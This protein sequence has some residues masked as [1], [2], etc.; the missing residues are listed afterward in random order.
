MFEVSAHPIRALERTESAFTILDNIIRTLALTYIDA[1]IEDSAA[2]SSDLLSSMAFNPRTV[3]NH[4]EMNSQRHHHHLSLSNQVHNGQY[5][6]APTSAHRTQSHVYPLP[7]YS[8]QPISASY[9]SHPQN[10]SQL[11]QYQASVPHAGI[12]SAACSCADLSLGR[13]W[14]G[15]QEHSPLWLCTPAWNPDWNVHELRREESRRLC[16][17]ALSITAGYTTYRAAMGA[18]IHD[19]FILQPSNVRYFYFC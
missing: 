11:L 10:S 3:H 7:L 16:W 1:D 15:A 12:E 18:P 8:R 2:S 13:N 6:G 17:Q 4:R 19:L 14:T 9:F 5:A